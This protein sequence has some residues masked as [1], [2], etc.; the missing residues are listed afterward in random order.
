[1][2]VRPQSAITITRVQYGSVSII[3]GE[4]TA[5]SGHIGFRRD[6]LWLCGLGFVVGYVIKRWTMTTRGPL[7]CLRRVT[8]VRLP[9]VVRRV[10]GIVYW[11]RTCMGEVAIGTRGSVLVA[12]G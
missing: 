10:C 9:L 3:S 4:H 6:R 8:L 2:Q 1:M 12:Y 5:G 11:L 7:F